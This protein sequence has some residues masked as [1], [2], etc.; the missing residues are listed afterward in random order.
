MGRNSASV[1]VRKTSRASKNRATHGAVSSDTRA[2][3][4]MRARSAAESQRGSRASEPVAASTAISIVPADTC[5][6][7][8]SQKTSYRLTSPGA[9][10]G[11][12]GCGALTAAGAPTAASSVASSASS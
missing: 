9:N 6:P 2:S 4:R 5:V 1:Y 8:P 7:A 10:P 3:Y 11:T 12:P